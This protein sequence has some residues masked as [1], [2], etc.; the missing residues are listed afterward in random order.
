ME[1]L[2]RY[3][4]IFGVTFILLLFIFFYNPNSKYLGVYKDKITIE[5]NYNDEGYSWT[6]DESN[7]NVKVETIN[8]NKYVLY[9]NKNGKYNIIY[10]YS[11]GENNKYEIKY[12][13][14]IKGNKIYWL[15]GEGTGLLDY[16]NPY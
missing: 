16:P 13:F 14:E 10:I 1:V 5:Y 11:N 9:P 6:Y 15:S 3:Y 2:V 4:I 8:N 12:E 7:T